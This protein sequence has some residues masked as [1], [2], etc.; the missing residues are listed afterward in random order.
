MNQKNLTKKK[1]SFFSTSK[2]VSLEIFGKEIRV[3]E[4]KKASPSKILR[5]DQ[6]RWEVKEKENEIHVTQKDGKHE[7]FDFEVFNKEQKEAVLK[8]IKRIIGDARTHGIEIQKQ[9][10]L[11]PNKKEKL[12]LNVW[13]FGGQHEYYNNHH[14]FLSARSV[15]LVVCDATKIIA[16]E[17]ENGNEEDFRDKTATEIV[18]YIL[19]LSI[20]AVSLYRTKLMGCWI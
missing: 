5:L 4:P 9:E 12:E 6:G 14:Y 8:R 3:F 17:D 11:I 16:E 20:S 1:N 7:H 13:D 15:F 18:Q 10:I 2:S 19:D